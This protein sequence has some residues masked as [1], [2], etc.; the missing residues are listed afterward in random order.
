MH[1]ADTAKTLVRKK[2]T[3]MAFLYFT[4]TMFERIFIPVGFIQGR[5]W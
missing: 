3:L 2:D 4:A 5:L 1:L